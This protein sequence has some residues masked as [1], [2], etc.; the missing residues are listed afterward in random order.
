[1]E[2]L[3]SIQQV[4]DL[5]K[6]ASAKT[7]VEDGNDIIVE[8]HPLLKQDLNKTSNEQQIDRGKKTKM[9]DEPASQESKSSRSRVLGSHFDLV[10]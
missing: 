10:V 8:G 9:E 1:M 4:T 2:S 7:N 3:N 5:I 6:K